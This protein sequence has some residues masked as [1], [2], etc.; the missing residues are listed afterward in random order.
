MP[1]FRVAFKLSR[2]LLGGVCLFSSLSTTGCFFS[3]AKPAPRAFRPPPVQVQPVVV[4]ANAVI[5]ESGPELEPQTPDNPANA[6]TLAMPELPGPPKPPAPRPPQVKASAPQPES[7]IV[8]PPKIT[9]LFS[10]DQRNELNRSY[11][12]FLRL[13]TR[14]LQTLS[15]K[16]LSADQTSQMER[17]RVFKGQAEEQFKHDD[18]LTAVEL[19]RRAFNLAEDLVSRVR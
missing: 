2:G 12:E 17:I 15:K 9:Q 10:A 1:E 5:E 19:A 14:D 7:P 11:E 4:T 16:R 3:H 8:P 6:A 13:L 18:L